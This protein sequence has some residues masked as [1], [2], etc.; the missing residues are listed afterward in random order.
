MKDITTD[1]FNSLKTL[2]KNP[3][4]NQVS[5]DRHSNSL[6]RV[7]VI[8]TDDADFDLIDMLLEDVFP[9]KQYR[10]SV[11]EDVGGNYYSIDVEGE[12]LIN[13]LIKKSYVEKKWTL[14]EVMRQEDGA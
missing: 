7:T 5:I 6:L 2:F 9:G 13:L 1:Q 3:Q 12:T 10:G 8:S 14:E 4:I 11:G